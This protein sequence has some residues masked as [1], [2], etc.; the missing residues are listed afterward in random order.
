MSRAPRL[1]LRDREILA[2]VGRFRMLTRGQ[3]K[4]W[5]FH[6]VSEPVVTRFFQRSMISGYLGVERLGGNGIQVA[7]LT[8][9]GRD[10]LVRD[11][12]PGADLFAATGPAAA[13]DFEHTRAIGDVAVWLAARTAAPDELLPSW[14]IARLFGG[15][16]PIVPD[17]LALW[18]AT[19]PESAAALAVEVDLATEPLRSV[20]LPKLRALEWNLKAWMPDALAT[21]LVLVPSAQRQQS[22]RMMLGESSERIGVEVLAGVNSDVKSS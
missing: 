19:G 4:R 20:F 12:V 3:V 6:D 9:K 14:M 10:A 22:L 11:G 1:T 15:R 7:W 8:R 18:R 21:I 17:L 13:K 16:L 2:A 5:F